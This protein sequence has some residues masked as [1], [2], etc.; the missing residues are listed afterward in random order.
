MA[1][2]LQNRAFM[3]RALLLAAAVAVPALAAAQTVPAGVVQFV[4]PGTTNDI[5]HG[6]WINATKC[7]N[8]TAMNVQLQWTATVAWPGSGASYQIYAANQDMTGSSIEC[9]KLSNTSTGLI[10][11]PVGNP[12]TNQPYQ[13]VSGVTETVDA[14][15]TAMQ[16]SSCNITTTITIFVCVQLTNSGGTSVGFAKG[17]LKFEVAPP[18]APT[19]VTAGPLDT[20]TL[21]VSWT[22]PNSSPRPTTTSCKR[23]R[24]RARRTRRRTPRTPRSTP[25][26]R[27]IL[28]RP[29]G[30][31]AASPTA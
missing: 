25:R 5:V 13:S 20:G 27:P 9:P 7:A 24:S 21:E 15:L 10:A 1:L 4:E 30:R 22:Q 18:G 11:N 29:T 23:S 6:A 3:R 19:G 12:I 17:Q 28:T 26:G 2:R 31:S 8:R 16:Q 14:F